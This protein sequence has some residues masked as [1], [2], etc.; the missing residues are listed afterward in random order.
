MIKEAS[1][2]EPLMRCRKDKDDVKTGGCCY[3]GI[4]SGET[5][6]LPGRGV[7]H[8]GGATLNQAL[9]WNVGTCR[10]DDKG[11]IQVED[12]LG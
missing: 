2:S 1:A 12:P 3:S 9:V 8:K 5:C 11:E 6:L 4:S 7:R 10:S